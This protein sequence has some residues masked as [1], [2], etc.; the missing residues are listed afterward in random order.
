MAY[1]KKALHKGGNVAKDD[2]EFLT[3]TS[4]PWNSGN[5]SRQ[6]YTGERYDDDTGFER[7]AIHADSD[8]HGLREKLPDEAGENIHEKL[9][10]LIQDSQ[11]YDPLIAGSSPLTHRKDVGD[12]KVRYA[13]KSGP[14]GNMRKPR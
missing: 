5:S 3:A 8:S 13:P 1:D 9:A 7:G 2:V 10:G 6:G 4:D 12:G 14:I 11:P